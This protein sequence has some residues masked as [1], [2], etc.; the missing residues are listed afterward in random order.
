MHPPGN[1]LR[2]KQVLARTGLSRATIH[3]KIAAGT[4]PAPL[5]LGENSRGWFSTRSMPG[6]NHG[7]EPTSTRLVRERR[8]DPPRPPHKKPARVLARTGEFRSGLQ[9]AARPADQA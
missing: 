6:L 5:I 1:V 7:R 8:H 3:R 2:I 9:P 4:F